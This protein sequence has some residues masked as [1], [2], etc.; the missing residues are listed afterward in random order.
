ME[1]NQLNWQSLL[2]IKFL[3]LIS[4]IFLSKTFVQTFVIDTEGTDEVMNIFYKYAAFSNH[5]RFILFWF[6]G[7]CIFIWILYL[8]N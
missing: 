6:I 5:F 3:G 8:I 1:V 7:P 4:G 2:V